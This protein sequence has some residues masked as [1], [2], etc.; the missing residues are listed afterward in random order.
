[1]DGP[2]TLIMPKLARYCLG[3]LEVVMKLKA[4]LLEVPKLVIE[5]DR[6]L[7][8]EMA[9]LRELR[10]IVR[11]AENDQTTSKLLKRKPLP[12]QWTAG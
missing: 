5:G 2:A 12:V 4:I 7:E 10:E 9:E 6:K 1:M 11:R 8:Q 3:W